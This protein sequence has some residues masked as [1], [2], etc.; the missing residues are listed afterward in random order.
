MES[1][2]ILAVNF[3]NMVTIT[4]MAVVGGL[5]LSLARKGVGAMSGGQ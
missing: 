2:N 4:L 5:L 1:E 3:P